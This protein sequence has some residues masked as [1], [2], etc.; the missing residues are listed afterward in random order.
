[1]PGKTVGQLTRLIDDDENVNIMLTRK[2]VI[3]K[4]E[5]MTFFSRLIDSEYIDYERVIPKGRETVAVMERAD[6]LSS[7]E[8]ASLVTEDKALGQAKSYVKATIEDGKIKI[9]SKSVNGSV[10]DEQNIEKSGADLVIG[11]NCR[12]FIDA[13]R[14]ADTDKIEIIFNGQLTSIIVKPVYKDDEKDKGEDY[15][16]M[17]SPVRMK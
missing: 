12:Y 9:E 14:A 6:L 2:H 11:F 1:M 13:L 5:N 8:R 17:I 3:F 16:Y 4:L 15:L 7:L 10:Y